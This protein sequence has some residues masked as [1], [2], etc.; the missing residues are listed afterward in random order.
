MP[1]Q[2]AALP[3]T[4]PITAPGPD[5]SGQAVAAIRSAGARATPARIQVLALLRQTPGALTHL[6][7]ERRLGPL[8]GDRVTLYRTLDWL[9]SAGLAHK[10]T[11]AARVFRYAATGSAVTH[12]AH[13]H[14]HCADCGQVF[15]LETA[16]PPPPALPAGFQ[17][18]RVAI[19]VHGQC[20]GCA[21]SQPSAEA[22]P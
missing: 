6:E 21:E 17:L 2:P 15:C 20:P 16:A 4:A 11:D 13:A 18:Q 5:A 10:T 19:D 7:V 3:I 9:V 12:G 14:F 8:A 1:K 22:R